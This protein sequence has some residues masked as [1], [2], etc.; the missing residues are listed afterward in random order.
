MATATKNFGAYDAHQDDSKQ[1]Q[2]QADKWMIGGTLLM[3]TGVLGIFG[4]PL[5]FYGLRLQMLAAKAG[6]SVRPLIVTLIGY[7]VII[8]SSL[9]SLGWAMD[10]FAN[11]S[12]INRVLTAGWGAVFDGGYFWQSAVPVRLVKKA[13]KYR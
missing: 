8:D 12:V 7:L 6:L 2:W 10:L 11:H 1:A 4:L 13:G 5:F 9:N 3:G